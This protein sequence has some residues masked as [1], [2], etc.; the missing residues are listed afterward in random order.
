MKDRPWK[1]LLIWKIYIFYDW[2][3]AERN[4]LRCNWKFWIAL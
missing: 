4:N 2:R 1:H 3:M